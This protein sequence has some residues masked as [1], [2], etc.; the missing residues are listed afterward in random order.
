[1][2]VEEVVKDFNWTDEAV[3][4]LRSMWKTHSR[5]VIA[6]TLGKGCTRNAVIGKGLR[7]G[8]PKTRAGGGIRERADRKPRS[9]TA[10][11]RIKPNAMSAFFAR[12]KLKQQ[13][14]G[15]RAAAPAPDSLFVTIT[16]IP[17]GGCKFAVTPHDV[18]PDQH[19]FCGVK[20]VD[21]PHCP[22]HAH[23]VYQPRV[24]AEPLS[25]RDFAARSQN[26]TRINPAW[27]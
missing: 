22:H 24:R 27:S 12:P 6:N 23:F 13:T 1:L 8:L 5:A 14:A 26:Q 15:Q 18:P 19:R 7:L 11:S 25:N 10:K 4:T 2:A 21:G 16:E 3:E 17:I 9:D 20:A